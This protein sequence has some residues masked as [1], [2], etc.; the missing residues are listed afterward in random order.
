[1]TLPPAEIERF[2]SVALP[3]DVASYTEP[4]DRSNAL[5]LALSE[6]DSAFSSGGYTL[7]LVTL[8]RDF[9]GFTFAIAA[10][11]LA[12]KTNL[13]TAQGRDGYL[14]INAQ[15]AREQLARVASGKLKP[16]GVTDSSAA[17][18]TPAA[19]DSPVVKTELPVW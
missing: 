15:Y 16:A 7:P 13:I 1:M 2:W 5:N 8:G 6:V 12:V 9:W 14:F 3:A 18:T 19:T 11:M 4:L 10:Y 17:P